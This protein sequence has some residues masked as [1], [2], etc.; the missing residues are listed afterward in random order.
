MIKTTVILLKLLHIYQE[1][2]SVLKIFLRLFTRR[3]LCRNI[4]IH[5]SGNKNVAP[6]D[7]NISKILKTH[8][9]CSI[10]L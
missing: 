1:T 3:E 5:F 9:A 6:I 7:R 8:Y 4:A 2:L 10:H